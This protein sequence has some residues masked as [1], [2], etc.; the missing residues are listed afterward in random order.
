MMDANGIAA[1]I[2]TVILTALGVYKKL[3]QI[4]A[5]LNGTSAEAALPNGEKPKDKPT[6]A[7]LNARIDD[8][9][10][11]LKQAKE[12]YAKAHEENGSL[13]TK[14]E[15]QIKGLQT[16]IDELRESNRRATDEIAK[17][18]VER[19]SAEDKYHK[20]LEKSNEDQQTIISMG[21]TLD[22]MEKRVSELEHQLAVN[23]S[24]E[25]SFIKF[26]DKLAESLKGAIQSAIQQ[27]AQPSVEANPT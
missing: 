19:D 11:D 24:V 16:Q 15:L 13:R 18:K 14:F 20:L 1:V 17:V 10:A 22:K 12:D 2:V 8:L 7:N 23:T 21:N 9:I 26:G 27:V 5:L 4:M 6:I 25:Q 3:P